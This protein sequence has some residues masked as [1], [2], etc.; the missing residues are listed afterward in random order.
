MEKII[1]AGGCFW[2]IEAYFQKVKGVLNTKVGYIDG[3]IENPTYEE[4][5]NG[6]GHAE[7]VYIEYSENETNLII[8]LKHF[9]R[10]I[11]PTQID[12]QG[13]DIG[14]QYRSAI[15]YFDN[16][17][18]KIINDYLLSIEKDYNK[19]IQT[20]VLQATKFYDAEE[21]HQKYLDKNPSGYCHI[22]LNLLKEE[23]K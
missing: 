14:K 8:L 3:L 11:D 4:V 16:N 6:S 20:E 9:F 10:I 18:K 13:N 17:S 12:R 23:L 19:K 22:N 7:A 1:L 5:C 2:G 21:Y 15:F